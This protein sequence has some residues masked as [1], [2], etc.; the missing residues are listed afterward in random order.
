[1]DR[2]RITDE[3]IEK[4][5][6]FNSLVE[7]F[8]KQ[9]LK[10]ARG[11]ESWRKNKKIVYSSIIAG[12]TVICTITYLSLN[13]QSQQIARH[14]KI[15]TPSKTQKIPVKKEGFI[16][17]PSTKLNIGYSNYKVNSAKGATISH[18]TATTIKIP[19]N[20]FIDKNG[21]DIVGEV[22]IQYREMHDMGDVIASGIPMGY[23]S[24]GIQ[25]QLETAGMFDI[26]GNQGGVPVFIKPDRSLTVELASQK[27]DDRFNQYYLDTV[28]Q[29]WK[30]LKRDNL[31]PNKKNRLTKFSA[32][33]ELSLKIKTLE[34]LVQSVIPMRIDSVEQVY[35]KK[36][37]LLPLVLAP[38]KPVKATQGRPNFKLEGSHDEFP[39]LD[40]FSNVVFE[41]GPENKN[42]SPELHEIT[43]SD[44]KI[45]RGPVNG[46]NYILNLYY[47]GRSE[48]LVVYPVIN[49]NDY[50]K[51]SLQYEK[52]L[53]DYESRLEKREKDEERLM[54]EMELKQAAFVAEQRKKQEE[55]NN[56][57]ATMNAAYNPEENNE[58]ASNF[59]KMS[60]QSRTTRIFNVAKFGIFNSDCPHPA[61]GGKVINPV[62]T[63]TANNKPVFA[64]IIYLVDHHNKTVQCI[65]RSTGYRFTFAPGIAYSLCVFN[66][67]KVFI[68]NKN[69]FIK[70]TEAENGKFMVS[71][72]PGESENLVD[73]KKALEI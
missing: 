17:A 51:A 16:K 23:D 49:E 32:S 4:H 46:K 3:E 42:Y 43:W 71:P 55:L 31:L 36:A 9:S 7:Q 47:R 11:D 59:N 68:C 52:K 44:V 27:A 40:A 66:K 21:N 67:N 35:A 24:A 58:L 37:K 39:E 13:K 48:K 15:N 20:S 12:V 10:K 33:K 26:K 6:D 73:F 50:Q 29:N 61:P 45:T 8:K 54:K 41:V 1:M 30:Y 38:A 25:H 57:R 69:M 63:S 19:A 2:P 70:T 60:N 64:D 65:D 22:N 56:A 34:H 62:F 53:A 28:E 18:S 72:L 14:E 5:K